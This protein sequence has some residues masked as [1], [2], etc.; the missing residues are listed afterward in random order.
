[1]FGR[2]PLLTAPMRLGPLPLA[3]AGGNP[4]RLLKPGR[5]LAWS[6]FQA[7]TSS[8]VLKRDESLEAP[9]A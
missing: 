9:R 6:G 4:S 1:M 5:I 8:M 3:F 7:G 2:L